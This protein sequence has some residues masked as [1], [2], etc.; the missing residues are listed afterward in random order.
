MRS[1]SQRRMLTL[2]MAGEHRVVAVQLQN[3]SGHP[4]TVFGFERSCGGPQLN[5]DFLRVLEPDLHRRQPVR[6]QV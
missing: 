2:A 6:L 3:I 1:S 5:L 4:V